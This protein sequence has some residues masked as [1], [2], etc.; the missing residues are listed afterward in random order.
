MHV[1]SVNANE[2][3][4]QF[5]YRTSHDLKSHLKK[6]NRLTH[7]GLGDQFCGQTRISHW[8]FFYWDGEAEFCTR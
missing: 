4:S 8:L 7:L 6:Q 1:Q 2:E 3:L 5:A